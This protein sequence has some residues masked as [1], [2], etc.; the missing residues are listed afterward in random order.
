[1][2]EFT[3]RERLVNICVMILNLKGECVYLCG[4]GVGVKRVHNGRSGI[5]VNG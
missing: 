3:W 5:L 1:M 4:G 2:D